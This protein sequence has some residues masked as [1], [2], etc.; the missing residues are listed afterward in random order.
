MPPFSY[1]IP[2]STAPARPPHSHARIEASIELSLI[3]QTSKPGPTNARRIFQ[4]LASAI[5][6]SSPSSPQKARPSADRRDQSGAW[7]RDHAFR[8][9]WRRPPSSWSRGKA[10]P[11]W[12]HSYQ[13]T[14]FGCPAGE[15]GLSSCQ[16]LLALM[17]SAHY[18]AWKLASLGHSAI[19]PTC[20]A[21]MA[22]LR[23][24]NQ[25]YV[26][27]MWSLS[28][29]HE[30]VCVARRGG[31]YFRLGLRTWTRAGGRRRKLSAVTL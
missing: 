9:G 8:H 11:T 22:R 16:R 2:A 26:W 3:V 1:P 28:I 23:V 5:G 17:P 14:N 19:W 24:S 13:Y 4:K 20:A 12:T 29:W 15:P 6:I 30:L 27:K 21:W 31:S 25:L 10:G 18:P 7:P